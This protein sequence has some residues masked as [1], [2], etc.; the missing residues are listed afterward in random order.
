[1]TWLGL[2]LLAALACAEPAVPLPDPIGPPPSTGRAVA[3]GAVRGY[4]ARPAG[5]DPAGGTLLL[6]DALDDGARA[7][8]LEA[9]AAGVWAMAIPP[10]IDTAASRAY[11][12]GLQGT[13]D[14]VTSRCLRVAAP[15][16]SPAEGTGDPP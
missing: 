15:C 5:R 1:M 10:E 7:A 13:G 14:S 4:L 2:R 16:V 8:A 11:V 6:V 3:M 12:A 9:A